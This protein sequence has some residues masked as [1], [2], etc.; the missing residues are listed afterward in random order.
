MIWPPTNVRPKTIG[1]G[2]LRSDCQS[3]WPPLMEGGLVN[4][5]A[6]KLAA[7]ATALAIVA[8][9]A[10][11]T[12][13][14]AATVPTAVPALVNAAPNSDVPPDG[15]A[16]ATATTIAAIFRTLAI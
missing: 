2:A 11:V 8:A 1:I 10:A 5:C 9:E 13:A 15:I 14:P 12:V 4:N 16:A 3:V 6:A 7:R